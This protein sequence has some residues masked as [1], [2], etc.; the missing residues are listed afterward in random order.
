MAIDPPD[1]ATP[2]WPLMQQIPQQPRQPTFC[3]TPTQFPPLTPR[4]HVRFSPPPPGETAPPPLTVD[5]QLCTSPELTPPSETQHD[6][7][8]FLPTPGRGMYQLS[9]HVQGNWDILFN[10]L[11][12]QDTALKVL[13]QEL[14]TTTSQH[15][16]KIETL[17][18]KIKS[19]H[20]QIQ[21]LITV[22]NQH[23]EENTDQLTK[24][25]KVM[26]TG[27][28][29]KSEQAIISEVRFM[30]EQLQLEVQKDI[31]EMQHSTQ[32]DCGQL[33]QEISQC[34]IQLNTVSDSLKE[35]KSE[36]SSYFKFPGKTVTDFSSMTLKSPP[37]S[38]AAEG[39][40]SKPH[41]SASVHPPP[42]HPTFGVKSDHLKLTFPTFGRS[43]DDSDPLLYLTK[44]HDFLALHPLEDTDIL[45]TFRTVLYGT[46]RD[47]W[48]VARS[49]VRTWNEF[50]SAFLAAFLSEDY[51]DELA[52]R[53]RTRI[54]G[55]KESIRD[56]AFTYR[57]LCK[58]W[59]PALTEYELVKLI[60]KN[61]KPYLASQL[62]SRVSTVDELVKLGHQLEKDYVHQLHYEGRTMTSLIPQ[63]PTSNRQG[64]RPTV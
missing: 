54:Q 5:M 9:E 61:I 37:H 2:N 6:L 21:A 19:N 47:W 14:A 52:E 39:E 1:I 44:C 3:S 48:E 51:E 58:R 20:Q 59:K 62:R 55:E 42:S 12:Q 60:L 30:V 26:V 23:D 46:A 56:F 49:S 40:T 17:T 53:V 45:A 4:T 29:Q 27:E 35:L 43:S 28:L 38:P 57:A 7:P 64:E 25:M 13:T 50:E 10:C 24:A 16:A 41:T 15:D 36:I 63:K 31:Q 11:K 18:A 32:K 33:F 8:G 22:K 34:S